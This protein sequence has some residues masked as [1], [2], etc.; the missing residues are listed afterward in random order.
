MVDISQ[1]YKYFDNT[2]TSTLVK[3]KTGATQSIAYTTNSPLRFAQIQLIGA[4]GLEPKHR[5]FSL[6]VPELGSFVPEINDKIIDDDDNTW[7]ILS[8]DN[9]TLS[10]RY[11]ATCVMQVQ[12][13]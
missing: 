10:V 8:V 3:D 1:D 13:S 12:D 2:F 5:N 7:R 9:R 6:P 4:V 11:L